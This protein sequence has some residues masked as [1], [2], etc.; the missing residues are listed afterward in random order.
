MTAWNFSL[1]V[2]LLP[3]RRRQ[4][5]LRLLKSRTAWGFSTMSHTRLDITF[6]SAASHCSAWHYMPNRSSGAAIVMAHGFGATRDTGLEPFA[7]RFVQEGYH[8]LLFDYRHFGASAGEP[9]QLLSIRKQL[10]DWQA[11]ISHVRRMDSVD[12]ERVALWGTSF[13]GG[14]VIHTAANDPRIAAV[15]AQNPMV[16]GLAAALN[17]VSYAGLG[18]LFKLSACGLL[19]Q[20]CGLLGLSPRLIPIAGA[21]DEFAAMSTH[22]AHQYL[23]LAPPGWRNEVTPRVMLHLATYRPIVRAKKLRQP[24]LLQACKNDTV[25]PPRVVE[26]LARKVGRRARLQLYDMGHFDIYLGTH[27]ESVLIDQLRF[28]ADTLSRKHGE[29]RA[30]EI[31]T[32]SSASSLS[33]M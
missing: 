20:L 28:F 10:E 8:V 17:V 6:A 13:S 11:A 1:E 32:R 27:R 16:D 25:A 14:H 12:P 19:D 26:K 5:F 4:R 33:P 9:R 7:E 30:E 18:R 22:D 29:A 21:R 2:A 24:L 23:A 15:C 31:L 3:V